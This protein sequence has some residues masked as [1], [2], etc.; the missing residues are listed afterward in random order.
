MNFF[1]GSREQLNQVSSYLDGSMVYGNIESLAEELRTFNNGE[2]RMSLT[3]EGRYL[4]PV[5]TDPQDGCNQAEEIMKKRYC[6]LSGL[7]FKLNRKFLLC[8]IYV[9]FYFL[10][11]DSRA[12]EN[13]HLTTMH[14]VF[15][16][17]HN[18]IAGQLYE[19]NPWWDDETIYQETRRILIAQIQHI[20]YKEFLPNILGK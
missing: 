9:F 12:N 1:I 15:A 14:L 16:R 6:F 7:S 13:T 2:L 18:Y 8:S 17:Q 10:E 3:N 4:L 11:G 5:S 20:T 19:I